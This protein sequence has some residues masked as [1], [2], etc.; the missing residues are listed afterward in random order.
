MIPE[1]KLARL[2]DRFHA[3]EAQL[4]SGTAGSSFVKLS[5]E[6][7]E[8]APVIAVADQYRSTA[9]QIAETETLIA[10]PATDSEMRAMALEERAELREKFGQLERDLQIQL[11]PKDAAD[12]SSAIVEIRAGT[13]GD[14]A[15]LFAGDLMRMYQR[16]ADSRGWRVELISASASEAGG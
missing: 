4:A 11:L 7:A 16:Y 1:N 14:E 10:D 8:L 15:A 6:H 2:S 3:I 5:K 9:R 13:G 12:S